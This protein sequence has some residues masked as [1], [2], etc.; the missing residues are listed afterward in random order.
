MDLRVLVLT[1]DSGLA[2]LIAAQAE[3]LGCKCTLHA[4]YDEAG[5][6]LAWADAAVIDLAGDGLDDLTRLRVEAP[7]LRVLGIA[8]SA[9]AE[10]AARSAGASQVLREPFAITDIVEA[11]RGLALRPRSDARVIDLRT[12]AA[13]SA[14]VVEDAPWFSTR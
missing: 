4:T 5:S 1:S 11:I 8:P 12:K 3:N 2:E 7:L 14:P 9:G 13:S 6:T 10:E